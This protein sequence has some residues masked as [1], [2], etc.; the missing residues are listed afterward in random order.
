MRSVAALRTAA[1]IFQIIAGALR[2]MALSAAYIRMP[3]CARRPVMAPIMAATA[4]VSLTCLP[5]GTVAKAQLALCQDMAGP[6]LIGCAT[7]SCWRFLPLMP[8]ADIQIIPAPAQIIWF[9]R[10]QTKAAQF[11]VP[12]TTPQA[13]HCAAARDHAKRY[14]NTVDR[15]ISKLRHPKQRL[16]VSNLGLWQRIPHQRDDA[17]RRACV[18]RMEI[19]RGGYRSKRRAAGGEACG[20]DGALICHD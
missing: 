13:F 5:R 16:P 7:R 10:W 17:A 12:L 19:V 15:R 1:L 20:V 3:W 2:S 14:P 8:T 9:P 11:C 6:I 4:K 18:G